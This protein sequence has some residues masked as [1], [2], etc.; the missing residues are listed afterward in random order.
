LVTAFL[1]DVVP[2]ADAP[3]HFVALDQVSWTADPSLPEFANGY[4]Q[5]ALSTWAKDAGLRL[6]Q[7]LRG[8]WSGKT[9]GHSYQDILI[10]DRV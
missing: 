2:I 3:L 1:V 4:K 5:K 7:A 9:D 8:L 6:R 10:F